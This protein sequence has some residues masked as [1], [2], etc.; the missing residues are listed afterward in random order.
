MTIDSPL[1]NGILIIEA[2]L[3]GSQMGNGTPKVGDGATMAIGS[4]RYPGTVI[5]VSKSG[6][7]VKVRSDN[8][9]LV[10]GSALSEDQRYEFT[11]NPNGAVEVFT[12]RKNGRYVRKGESF[13]GGLRASFGHRDAYS[14]PHF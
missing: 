10:G 3:K 9:K 1:I 12:R 6:H 13:R 2:R 14:D 11:P 5:E 8:Y 7:T 4:D